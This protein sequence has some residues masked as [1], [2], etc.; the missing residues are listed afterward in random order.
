MSFKLY[1][2]I[3]QAAEGLPAEITTYTEHTYEESIPVVNKTAICNGEP[4]RETLISRGYV[5]LGECN[6]EGSLININY[7]RKED[8][9]NIVIICPRC[10]KKVNAD[11]Q[12]TIENKGKIN[13][14]FCVESFIINSEKLQEELYKELNKDKEIKDIKNEMKEPTEKSIKKLDEEEK[15][16]VEI[17]DNKKEE[18]KKIIKICPNCETK[19]ELV[20]GQKKFK[21]P[22]CKKKFKIKNKKK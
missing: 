21:C 8:E 3:N 6:A 13:C 5:L 9:K 14:S 17:L 18:E 22:K 7:E 20:E 16:K 10:N 1:L 15:G 2:P 11:I 4:A 19:I 12:G